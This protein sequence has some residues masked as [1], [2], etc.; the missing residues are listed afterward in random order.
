MR[1]INIVEENHEK[2][3]NQRDQLPHSVHLTSNTPTTPEKAP[4]QLVQST[5]TTTSET[6]T[7]RTLRRTLQTKN[8]QL[9]ILRRKLKTSLQKNRRL[10]KTVITSKKLIRDLRK[11]ELISIKSEEML[12]N[13]FT[14]ESRAIFNRVANRKGKGKGSTFP[15]ELKAFAFTL[16]FYSAKAYEFVRK[17]LNNALPHQS[18]VRRWYSKIPADPGFTEPAFQT[19]K[20]KAD[21]ERE[22][23]KELIV[24]LMLDEMTIKK[25]TCWDGVKFRG[26]VDLGNDEVDDSAPLAKDA[27]VFMVVNISGSWKV[28][29]AYFLVD[30]LTGVE[31]ANLVQLCI[32]RLSDACIKVA[33]VTCDGPSCHFTMLKALGANLN[34][35]DLRAYFSHPS[36]PG[37]NIRV[38]L[39]VCHMLKLVRNTLGEYGIIMDGDGKKIYWRFLEDLNELQES[40]GLRLANKLK[41][42]HIKWKSQKMKVKLASQALSASVADAIEFCDKVLRLPQ[43]ADS[44]ATVRFIR[45]FDRLFDILN[46][47]S[48]VGKGF[49]RA[50]TVNTK[51][52]WEPFLDSASKYISTLTTPSGV[53]MFKTRRKTAFVGFLA[54][55]QST[56]NVFTDLVESPHTH[57]KFLLMYKFSQDHLELF[58]EAIRA[59]GGFNNNPTVTQFIAAYKR[60]FM[61]TSIAGN[62]GNCIKRDG[63]YI[64]TLSQQSISKS[65]AVTLTNTSLIR[66]YGLERKCTDLED[67]FLNDIPD[68]MDSLSEYKKAAISYIAGYAA[69]MAIKKLVCEICIAALGSVTN[70]SFTPFLAFK[71]KGGLFKPSISVIRVCEEAE[72]CFQRMLAATAGK[73]PRDSGLGDVIALATFQNLGSKVF[74]SLDEHI[75]DCAIEDNHVSHLIKLVARCFSTIRF[76]HLSKRENDKNEGEKVRKKL[77]KLILF[78][79]Q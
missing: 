56:K 74:R 25:L 46:S 61:R 70:D 65:D 48:C 13:V 53:P 69:R 18:T 43:F 2:N 33:S 30:G 40:E 17:K 68:I 55:I 22:Q 39:D 16:Q 51:Y 28:P 15:P 47:R 24:S 1:T 49:K 78:K 34:P 14:D 31:R 79:H 42:A 71:D 52:I 45:M 54:C 72:K 67:D 19:L 3:G 9:Q 5:S 58:F 27:L 20:E 11:K 62:N 63:T 35:R 64:L 29:V 32:K 66:K 21:E 75:L 36:K 8:N 50:L 41:P 12:N 73:L 4:A 6:D 26:Y 38:F 44:E 60:L 57:I 23:G 37:S 59:C 7:P 10:K 76:H 77:S